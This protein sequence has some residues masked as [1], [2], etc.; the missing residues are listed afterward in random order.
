MVR[1]IMF[2]PWGYHIEYCVL[3]SN[4]LRHQM[5]SL[6]IVQK[7]FGTSNYVQPMGILY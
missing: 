4:K 2:D 7:K 3:Y 1:V 6:A 5:L